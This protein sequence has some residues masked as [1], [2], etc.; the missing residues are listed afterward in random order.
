[1]IFNLLKFNIKRWCV[2]S[3]DWTRL[4]MLNYFKGLDLCFLTTHEY[5]NTET[6]LLMLCFIHKQPSFHTH[7]HKNWC[8]SE[9]SKDKNSSP[10]EF[11]FQEFF[12]LEL[13]SI[14]VTNSWPSPPPLKAFTLFFNFL[15]YIEMPTST[16][17]YKRLLQNDQ[18]EIFLKKIK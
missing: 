14:L 9:R 11:I 17:N 16:N 18:S 1:M 10:S 13:W 6:K 3:S 15:Y 2:Q 5:K 4:K 12:H 7:V 8:K